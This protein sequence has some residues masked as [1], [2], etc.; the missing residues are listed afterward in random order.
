MTRKVKSKPENKTKAADRAEKPPKMPS[1]H[2]KPTK[3]A[4][5]IALLQREPGASVSSISKKFGWQPHTTR[6]ALTG[7]RKSGFE[8]ALTKP[9]TGGP[10]TYRIVGDAS[11]DR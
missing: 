8:I 2:P 6:A 9:E 11:S 5:L 7:L 3:K 10:G 1:A 4:Q